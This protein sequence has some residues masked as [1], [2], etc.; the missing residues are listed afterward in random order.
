MPRDDRVAIGPRRKT[1]ADDDIANLRSCQRAL[2][3]LT[4]FIAN[5][6]TGFGP[7]IAVY[8]TSQGWTQT[9]IGFALSV[10]TVT[11]M[12]S[13]VPAGALVDM[14]RSKSRIAAVS[15]LAFAASA[16]LFALWPTRPFVY[17]AEVL[18][19]FSSCTLGPAIAAIS[20]ALVGQRGL[21]LRLARNARYAA[22]GNGV[23]AALMGAV[24]YYVSQRSIFFLTAAL[25]IPA[26]AALVPLWRVRDRMPAPRYQH[27]AE[28][29]MHLGRVLADR[30]LIILAVCAMLFTFA[31]AAMLPLA[32]IAL[33]KGVGRQASLLIAACIVLPQVLVAL[34]SPAIARLADVR[35]RRAALL[36]GF[37][38]LPLRGL[39]FALITDPIGIVLIQLLDGIAGA[40]FGVLV[41][42]VTADVA[43]RSGHFNFAL[44][45]IGLA[46]G[47]GG[48]LSTALAGWTADRLGDPAAFIGLALVGLAAT[49]LIWRGMPETRPAGLDAAVRPTRA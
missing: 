31:D 9:G 42:L 27:A 5:I 1:P 20:L 46:I 36:L 3:W 40:C 7:F 14:V 41:P 8:L 44:G 49:L 23:G 19:G 17:L 22:I 29:L 10:G 18:H 25:T 24:G 34:F 16:L 39:L 35:G 45:V 47:I 26:L 28:R 21:G 43:G 30:R 13:Q 37:A 32:G 15:I 6:Q 11:A 33:T 2:D 12:A 48:T 4:L 38:M